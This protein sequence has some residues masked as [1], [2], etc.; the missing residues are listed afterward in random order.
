IVVLVWDNVLA[1]LSMT[2]EEGTR[3]RIAGEIEVYQDTLEIIPA[4]T[5]DI[6]WLEAAALPTPQPPATPTLEPAVTAQV[7]PTLTPTPL[8][9]TLTPRPTAAPTATRGTQTV[10]T[11]K[12]TR[13]LIGQTATIEGRI[14]EVVSFSSG[15]KFYVDDGSGRAALWVLQ[16]VYSQLDNAAQL[17]VGSTV[18]AQGVVEEYK[19]ELEV[20]PQSASDVTVTVAATPQ[21]VTITRLADLSAANVGQTVTVQGEIVEVVPFSSGIKYLLDDGSARVTLLLWQNVYD[22]VAVKDQLVV[23]AVVQATGKV[24][25]Y[26]GAIEIVPALGG[27]VAIK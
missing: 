2:F 8:V 19:D 4:A 10:P 20:A 23:G 9:P 12:L 13:A 14:V 6:T 24:N 25:E 27:D 3:V 11:G 7:T 15:V 18:R 1:P 5:G 21:P 17:I 26:R 16:A 22:L